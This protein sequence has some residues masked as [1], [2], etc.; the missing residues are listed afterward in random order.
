MKRLFSL[1]SACALALVTCAL[2]PAVARAEDPAPVTPARQLFMDAR[3]LT[4]EGKYSEACPKL[5]EALRLEVGVGTQFNLADCWE[6]IGRTASAHA[7]FLGAAASAK[8]AGQTDRE[9]VLRDRAAALEPR[10]SR[11][12]IEVKGTDPKLTVKR[13]DLPLDADALGK[14]AIVDPGKYTITARAPGKKPWEKVVEVASGTPV[15]TVEVPELEAA[16]PAKPAP[17]EA[18]ADADEAKPAGKKAPPAPSADG[19][20]R[21][22]RLNYGAITVAGIGVAGIGFGAIM[23]MK[24]RSANNDAKDI[25]PSNHG[26]SIKQIQ[27]HDRLVSDARSDRTWSYVG[28]GLGGAVLAGAGVLWYVQRP[29]THAGVSWQ[30]S[31][32][33]AADGSVGALVN[34][35]F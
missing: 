24:Y 25:C 15:V 12:V 28:L 11:L 31:P 4:A 16:K 7:L 33:V 18:D 22:A 1:P 30:A 34:G 13:N 8:A 23:G 19:S 26:C 6:H 21:G 5:E 17:K 10:L 3:K 35:R 20:D 27:D 32:L 29:K 14:A 9:Q 2:A